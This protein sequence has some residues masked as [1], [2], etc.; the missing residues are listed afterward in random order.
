MRAYAD[1]RDYQRWLLC[2]RIAK[3]PKSDLAKRILAGAVEKDPEEAFEPKK[4]GLLY[5]YLEDAEAES[6]LV[7]S[8]PQR[9]AL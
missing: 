6:L 5:D 3:A 1:P 4:N 7:S 2:A 9:R 8:E